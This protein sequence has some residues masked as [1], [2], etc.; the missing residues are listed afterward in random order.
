MA[1]RRIRPL[2]DLLREPFDDEQVDTL[3]RSIIDRVDREQP[4]AA[5]RWQVGAALVG[6]AAAVVFV[7]Y[8]W[9]REGPP[10]PD[11]VSTQ[12]IRLVSGAVLGSIDGASA[13][14]L[15][16][17]LDDGSSIEL[18]PETDLLAISNTGS[19]L[20]LELSLGQARFSVEPNG[21]R[22][23]TIDAE[24]A[25][26]DVVGTEFVVER[27]ERTVR[28]AVSDGVVRV[29]SELLDEERLLN[30]GQE[31]EVSLNAETAEEQ[32]RLEQNEHDIETP[33][34]DS[35][36]GPAWRSL[37]S[38]GEYDAAYEL[39]GSAGVRR[40][41]ERALT[42][43]ELM[44]I[45]DVA[46]LSG[47]PIEALSPLERV[48]ESYSGDRRSPVAAFTLGRIQADSLR[49]HH[50]AAQAF[51]RCLQLGPPRALR[52][53]AYARLAEAHARSG[54]NARAKT[55]VREYLREF[56][57]GRRARDLSRLVEEL[58]TQ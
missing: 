33:E 48:L 26:I 22:E 30:A 31:L 47:H 41:T 19:R 39:L 52:E 5:W 51:E 50:R 36:V 21:P 46:R 4:K 37:A 9:G 28:V 27:S 29:R 57:S 8:F 53:H 49:N 43:A 56:P 58:E 34:D 11:S 18:A 23:W 25:F 45:A 13:E 40:E 3:H 2:N 14:H 1:S 10:E 17:D 35:S 54:N 15:R 42:V 7:F 20:V 55:V 44:A 38:S 16:V 32:P 12:P 6:A 24:I